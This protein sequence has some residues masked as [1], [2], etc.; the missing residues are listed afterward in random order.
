MIYR[1]YMIYMYMCICVYVYMCVCVYVYMCI[2]VYMYICIHVYMYIC[3]YVYMY[4]CIYVYMYICMYVYMYICIYVYMYICIYVF[5]YI[6]IY[7]Y[8]Y[9]C[10][11]VCIY[12]IRMYVCM[13]VYICIYVCRYYIRMYVQVS[14]YAKSNGWTQVQCL[15]SCKVGGATCQVSRWQVTNLV[16]LE[17][18]CTLHQV[19]S[20]QVKNLTAGPR[21]GKIETKSSCRGGKKCYGLQWHGSRRLV[22]GVPAEVFHRC[23]G[24]SGDNRMTFR[25]HQA[26]KE[27]RG[28]HFKSHE[29]FTKRFVLH[30]VRSVDG[31]KSPAHVIFSERSLSPSCWTPFHRSMKHGP[32]FSRSWWSLKPERSWRTSHPL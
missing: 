25:C 1:I 16:I 10:I 15:A 14:T 26:P 2:Y 7:V 3:I 30:W 20:K 32:V 12:Y 28:E 17:R 23:I 31:F 29:S 22:T 4:I 21:T 27:T 18:Y 19:L 6:C 11:Y 9:I 24:T 5:M 13:Y 8:M